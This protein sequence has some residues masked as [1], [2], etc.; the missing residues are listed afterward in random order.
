MAIDARHPREIRA[1]IRR[2]KRGCIVNS[3]TSHRDG[4]ALLI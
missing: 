2:G 4:S 1:D 3:I